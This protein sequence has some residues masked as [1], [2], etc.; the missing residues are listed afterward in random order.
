MK[1]NIRNI[2]LTFLV[3][4]SIQVFSQKFEMKIDSVIKL[5]IKK[6]NDK[7][8]T[9]IGYL[10]FSCVNYGIRSRAYLFWSVNDLTYIQ[11]YSDSEYQSDPVKKFEPIEIKDSV[12]FTFYKNN[13]ENLFIEDVKPFNYKLDSIVGNKYYSTMST[14]SHSCFTNIT[15]QIGDT[16]IQKY[17]DHYD[18]QEFDREKVYA[19]KMTENDIAKW[20]ERGWEIETDS[21]FENHPIKNIHF[22]SNN[23]LKIVE[24]DK[25]L[26]DFID[27]MES[28]SKF[29][30]FKIK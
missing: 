5:E 21:I 22:E 1:I 2:T 28:E 26:T 20:K 25:L 12:F 10:K 13:K 7:K 11:K 27:K 18:L 29:E 16:H 30:E 17:F 15:M 23:N 14:T 6:L 9:E 19:S 4:T 24:W 3:F 8:V